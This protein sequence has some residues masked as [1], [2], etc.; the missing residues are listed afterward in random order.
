MRLA[1]IAIVLSFAAL[2]ASEF[3]ARR[4]IRRTGGGR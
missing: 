2:L 3:L 4:I 1:I